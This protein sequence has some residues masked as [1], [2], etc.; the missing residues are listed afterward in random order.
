MLGH[1]GPYSLF[2]PDISP[3]NHPAT[4]EDVEKGRAVFHLDGIGKLADL[5]L[6]AVATVRQEKPNPRPPRVL[7]VQ[8]EIGL[9][10]RT[11]Y[12]IIGNG[13]IRPAAADTLAD[14]KPIL[15]NNPA[16]TNPQP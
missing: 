11:T 10:G 3:L 7:V 6:P 15:E 9:D 8:A 1:F 16:K 13:D 4:A 12:G 14:I 2:A 5:K